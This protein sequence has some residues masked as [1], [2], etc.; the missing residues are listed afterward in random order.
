VNVDFVR[1][2]HREGR[3]EGWVVLSSG[4]RIRMNRTGWQKL[5]SISA[6]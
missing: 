3:M 1:E 4:A 6:L 2:I 5:V